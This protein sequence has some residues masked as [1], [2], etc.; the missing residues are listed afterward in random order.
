MCVC[1]CACP[2]ARVRACVRAFVCAHARVCVPVCVRACVCVP[3]CVCPCVCVCPP[4][5][6][7]Q[8]VLQVLDADGESG[9][10]RV[11]L[12]G[13]PDPLQVAHSALQVLVLDGDTHISLRPAAVDPHHHTGSRSGVRTGIK[14][15][16]CLISC[17]E[18]VISF[19][20]EV[21]KCCNFHI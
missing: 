4:L 6:P 8:P 16:R 3:V 7:L 11:L 19:R 9:D 17:A 1:V 5:L 2:P 14:T 18:R 13:P 10:H 20:H 21:L 12:A 15:T